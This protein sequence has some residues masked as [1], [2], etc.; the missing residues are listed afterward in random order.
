MTSDGADR[1]RPETQRGAT[2]RVETKSHFHFH[3][4]TLLSLKSQLPHPASP[5]PTRCHA[6]ICRRWNFH[7]YYYRR[8]DFWNESLAQ[9]AEKDWLTDWLALAV[10]EFTAAQF[11]L[12]CKGKIRKLKMKSSAQRIYWKLFYFACSSSAFF[13]CAFFE[14]EKL[15]CIRWGIVCV[16]IVQMQSERLFRIERH[17]FHFSAR[18]E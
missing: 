7:F 9:I 17:F 16:E 3:A 13:I 4:I 5:Q 12:M 10:F 2:D 1:R 15:I 11:S 6:V 14:N 8:I 18:E